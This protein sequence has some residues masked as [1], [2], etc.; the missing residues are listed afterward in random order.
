MKIGSF[1]KKH[2]L[3]L[4]AVLTGVILVLASGRAANTGEE[5][6]VTQNEMR[7]KRLVESID[8][9]DDALAQE[10]AGQ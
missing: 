3:I 8:G 4:A 10:E 1:N 7:V 6:D 9:I 2:I 5:T